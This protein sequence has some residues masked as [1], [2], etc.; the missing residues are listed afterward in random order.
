[1]D[2]LKSGRLI[3]IMGRPFYV[4][5]DSDRS[6]TRVL[7]GALNWC[8]GPVYSTGNFED[9]VFSWLQIE[10]EARFSGWSV[11][12]AGGIPGSRSANGNLV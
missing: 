5:I 8:F 10:S 11:P 9:T 12:T 1:M 6:V 7:R 3:L 2:E 4:V